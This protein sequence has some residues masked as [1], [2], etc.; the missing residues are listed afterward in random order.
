MNTSGIGQ[1]QIYFENFRSVENEIFGKN[2]KFQFLTF[3]IISNSNE[4]RG[5]ASHWR[6][7]TSGIGQC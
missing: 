6:M 1:C 7:N 4:P 3:P 5:R 2:P